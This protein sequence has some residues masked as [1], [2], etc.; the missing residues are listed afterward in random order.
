MS[1]APSGGVIQDMLAAGKLRAET[2]IAG[3]HCI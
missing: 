2:P 1:V 3:L